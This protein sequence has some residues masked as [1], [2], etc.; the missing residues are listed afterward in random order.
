MY[1][2][3]FLFLLLFLLNACKST[4]PFVGT[5]KSN[6]ILEQRVKWHVTCLNDRNFEGLEAIYAEDFSGWAPVINFDS[7]ASLIA[8]LKKNYQ[9]SD[10]E[11][12]IQI[13]AME[14][15]NNLAYV[16]LHWKALSPVVDARAKILFEKD[17]LEIWRKDKKGNWQLARMLFFQSDDGYGIGG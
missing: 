1:R 17:L 2:L 11:I 7:K 9:A 3:S 10:T 15:G 12:D 5:Q 14:A 8:Q 16:L 13:L 4:H 6:P